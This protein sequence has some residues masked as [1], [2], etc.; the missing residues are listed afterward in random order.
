MDDSCKTGSQPKPFSFRNI[1]HLMINSFHRLRNGLQRFIEAMFAAISSVKNFFLTIFATS[2]G[3][4]EQVAMLIVFIFDW[5]RNIFHYDYMGYFVWLITLPEKYYTK[6]KEQTR[7]YV[8]MPIANAFTRKRNRIARTFKAKLRES[9]VYL[10]GFCELCRRLFLLTSDY[11]PGGKYTVTVFL[12]VVAIIFF[13]KILTVI[14]VLVQILGFAYSIIAFLLHPLLLT[15]RDILLIFEPLLQ[16][17]LSL[18]RIISQALLSTVK[19]IGFFVWLNLISIASGL[20]RCWQYFVN[21]RIV[22]LLWSL[23]VKS[24]Y[25]LL[26]NVVFVFLP[27]M[28][29][30]SYYF[31]VGFVDVSSTAYMWFYPWFIRGFSEA[32]VN[33]DRVEYLTPSGIG[34]GVLIFWALLLAFRF[35]NRFSGTFY[36]EIDGKQYAIRSS[37]ASNTDRFGRDSQRARESTSGKTTKYDYSRRRTTNGESSLRNRGNGTRTEERE[38][39]SDNSIEGH[40]HYSSQVH[41]CTD[42][43]TGIC[44]QG[45]KCDTHHCPLPYHWQYRLSLE[46]WKSFSTEDNRKIEDLYCDPKNDIITSTEIDLIVKSYRETITSSRRTDAVK[47]D[48][49]SMTIQKSYHRADLRRLSTQSYIKEQGSLAT[50]WRWYRKEESGDWVKYG[51]ENGS[52]PKQ[53]ELESSFLRRDGNYNYKRNGQEFRLQFYLNPMCE[54]SFKPYSK[55][56]VRRRPVF[57]SPQDI[58]KLTRGNVEKTSWFSFRNLFKWR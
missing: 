56:I 11:T 44:Q 16:I 6:C 14:R 31:G 24:A 40:I 7:E 36:S 54:K 26:E 25:V 46:G 18:A 58:G 21:S 37:T 38:P 19:A 29:K 32:S 2:F 10:R 27:F 33:I 51:E 20:F 3:A 23:F 30:I 12:G 50:Q 39:A 49:E 13:L 47:V 43:I 52:D 41:I 5:V 1:S 9:A 42:Y 17:V 55:K 48:F 22:I 35:R 4:Y 34:S 15:L 53:E 45:S 8:W 57:R 28:T